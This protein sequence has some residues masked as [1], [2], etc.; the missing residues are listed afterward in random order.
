[1]K[2]VKANIP[3]GKLIKICERGTPELL[4]LKA[5]ERLCTCAQLEINDQ[6]KE[7]LERYSHE[8]DDEYWKN[9]MKKYTNGARCTFPGYKCPMPCGFA[10]GVKM[11]RLI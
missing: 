3:Q 6:T 7:T 5:K 4:I 1:M 10:D 11:D 2:K 8:C 9:E